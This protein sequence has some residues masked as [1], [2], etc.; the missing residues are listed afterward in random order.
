MALYKNKYRIESARLKNWDY[1]SS[2]NYF[3]TICTQKRAHFLGEIVDNEMILSQTGKYANKYWLEIPVHFSYATLDAFVIMPDH[4]HGIVV[5]NQHNRDAI[6]RVSTTES[7]NHVSTTESINR[8]STT[9][10]INRVYNTIPKPGTGGIT[11]QHNPMLHDNLSRIIRWYK[12]RA[13]FESRQIDPKFSWQ[14]RF[15]DH[16]IRNEIALYNIRRY[17]KNNPNMWNK[18]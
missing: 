5:I 6:N 7:I 12:G 1:S 15:Y 8:V 2:G 4:I 17:I 3:I 9:E 14:P 18:S 11:K 10:S 13:T 16:V